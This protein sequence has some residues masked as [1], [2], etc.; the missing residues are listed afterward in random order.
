MEIWKPVPIDGYCDIYSIS[1][2]GRLK[3]VRRNKILAINLDNYG[4]PHYL[5]S[6]NGK[7]KT[8]TAHRLVAMA[9]IENPFNLP[10][11][12]HKDEVKTNNSV[13]NLEWCTVKYNDN[14]G[15]KNKRAAEKLSKP[16]VQM[17]NGIVIATYPN[18]RVA[19]RQTGVNFSKIRMCCRGIRKRAG[20]YEWKDI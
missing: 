14:Y 17:L 16:I 5:M 9:F 12:N 10:C 6:A 15:T 2:K 7:R 18:S 4:Y 8:I 20:G 13:D 1:S 3:N 19:E 11:V